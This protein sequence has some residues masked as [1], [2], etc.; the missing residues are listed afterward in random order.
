MRFAAIHLHRYGHLADL[1][2]DLP[3]RQPDFHILVGANE[4]G[5]STTQ[6]ALADWLY[7]FDPQTPYAYR[8]PYADLMVG[9]CLEAGDAHLE[10]W[11]R[12][13]NKNTLLD[14]AGEPLDEAALQRF[15]PSID[16]DGF[17]WQFSLNHSRL[18]EGGQAIL[19]NR[20]DLGRM[21]FQ[22]GAG[23]DWLVNH[24]QTLDEEATRLFKPSGRQQQ[25]PS[26]LRQRDEA[27]KSMRQA[28]L[29]GRDY[30][31]VEQ[32]V[33][34]AQ[35]RRDALAAE[36]A[37][38]QKERIQLQRA[39]QVIPLLRQIDLTAEALQPMVAVPRLPADYR[40]RLDSA[41]ETWR[42]AQR[43]VATS[44]RERQ[45]A[46]DQLAAIEVDEA[47]LAEAEAIGQLREQATL[48][49]QEAQ[50]LPRQQAALRTAEQRL[51]DLLR[52][53]GRPEL[54]LQ[55]L[56]AY[57]PDTTETAAVRRLARE[58][59]SLSQRLEQAQR[60]Q[61]ATAQAVDQARQNASQWP[62]LPDIEPLR[63]AI[64]N[65]DRDPELGA[66][67]TQA[68]TAAAEKH[69][70]IEQARQR[71]N[72]ALPADLSL[73]DVP[74]AATLRDYADRFAE[75]ERQLSEL[76]SDQQ[77]NARAQQGLQAQWRELTTNQGAI[78]RETLVAAREARATGWRLLRAKYIDAQALPTGAITAFAGADDLPAA[79]ERAVEQAD[80]L[81][82][83]RFEA[84]ETSARLGHIHDELARLAGEAATLEAQRQTTQQAQQTLQ[85]AWQQLWTATAVPP[86]APNA[87]LEWRTALETLEREATQWRVLIQRAQ[88]LEAQVDQRRM[89]LSQALNGLG[90]AS[91]T[92]HLDF[93]ALLSQARRLA[94]HLTQQARER[95]SA[96]AHLAEC[97]HAAANQQLELDNTRQAL[98]AWQ[99]AWEAQM[100]HIGRR[101][102]TDP[103]DIDALLD[104]W[105]AI[106]Q[107]HGEAET[108]RRQ[109]DTIERH[110]VDLEAR[111]KAL[112][113]Q[114]A[115]DSANQAPAEIARELAERLASARTNAKL[116]QDYT[117]ACDHRRQAYQTALRRSQHAAE[118][119][120]DTLQLAGVET[121]TEAWPLLAQAE[122]RTR[123]ETKLTELRADLVQAGQ[124]RSESELRAATDGLDADALGPRIEALEAQE[125]E[126]FQQIQDVT[127][128]LT[129]HQQILTE[130]RSAQSQAAQAKE[131]AEQ[132]GTSALRTAERYIQLQATASVLRYAINRYRRLHEGPILRIASRLF[133]TLTCGRYG[134][135]EVDYDSGETPLL[136]VRP[137]DGGASVPVTGLSDG[138]RDQ[139]YLALR[140]AA[141]ED[142]LSKAVHM[143]FIADDLFIHFDDARAAAGL[144]VLAELAG[145]T[146]VLLLTHHRHLLD[147]AAHTIPGR[148]TA[149]RLETLM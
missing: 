5:K 70:E 114:L 125:G 11:R 65:A 24:L 79:Y 58:Y 34:T 143:P 93:A 40:G 18:R 37:A 78:A 136:L 41:A 32:A 127:A 22:A 86:A 117:A 35:A 17:R 64:A 126:L 135:L 77:R 3:G 72:P 53:V 122:E 68:R 60:Q 71:L 131:Q 137:A 31:A 30:D 20:N 80:R 29:A 28:M 148:Y 25:L 1:K 121:L 147:I 104:N 96:M 124:G 9:G 47:I 36:R 81:A 26:A 103:A 97:E 33:G 55:H 130:Y 106:R 119:L 12:K 57:L 118:Q 149:H 109:I 108:L 141:I 133:A 140:L 138:G 92:E 66:R 46:A 67:A 132:A 8:F 101:G 110:H 75:L 129:Q 82:D 99:Q 56:T 52:D 10:V 116:R 42:T 95:Q 76:D 98:A 84:A 112:A 61:Q 4:I 115:P 100:A 134:R 120:A 50:A 145:Q 142:M 59:A 43:E 39:R 146:Q 19:A 16:R 48:A 7:G 62:E 87:M 107:T 144:Q 91:Q 54:S 2:L 73:A 90:Q 105:D 123:L 74:A 63:A 139:L 27:L 111:A 49:A 88:A 83:E 45:A 94:E 102:D 6:A 89:Q 113:A 38:R 15:L 51:H 44:E 128:T 85:A 14:R 69:T 21:L 13:G 23:L